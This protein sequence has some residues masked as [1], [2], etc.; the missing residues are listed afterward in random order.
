MRSTPVAVPEISPL[1]F[2]EAVQAG[3][4][5]QVLDVRLPARVAA[6]SI[7]IVPRHRFHNIPG[8]R[9]LK[10]ASLEGTGIDP[11]LPIVVV[12]GHGFD[13]G[14]VA[15]HLNQ[16]GYRAF[17]LHGGMA[18]WMSLVV[19]R[20]GVPPPS[21]DRLVQFD[22]VGKGALGYLLV[23]A[24]E[25]LIVDPPRDATTMMDAARGARAIVVGVADTHVHADYISGAAA[26]AQ[27]L[28]VPY[29]LHPKDGVYPYDDRPGEIRF[30]RV[31]DGMTIPV[32]RCAVKVVHTPGHTEGSVSY[33]IDDAAALTGDFIFVESIGR[34]DLAGKTAQWSEDLWRS[35][36]RARREW[37]E[38]MT[39]YP[40]HYQSAEERRPDGIV[41]APFGR[42]VER[43]EELRAPSA[44]DFATWVAAHT[45]SFP[46]A[47]RRIKAI[48]IGLERVDDQS[49]DELEAGRN[50]CA[51]A[52][53]PSGS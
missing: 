49:A 46:D 37:P 18:A 43:S 52:T 40:G 5:L 32:G 48:N 4:D 28:G 27:L 22:R 21:L 13:S 50:Q 20:P 34:P 17:S 30:S 45:G 3:D 15:E 24:G 29:Y 14:V 36:Q 23:S 10:R 19:A 8:S 42:I 35:L 11:A 38:N 33:L 6:V 31:D 9:V 47:Y 25:A 41:A 7:D 2:V 1:Q 51:L 26:L 12:C 39:I 44:Q 16:S 53:S